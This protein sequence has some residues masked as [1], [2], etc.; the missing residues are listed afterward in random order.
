MEW[1]I[2]YEEDLNLGWLEKHTIFFNHSRFDRMVVQLNCYSNLSSEHKYFVRSGIKIKG[3][4][5]FTFPFNEDTLKAF[6]A[7]G[8]NTKKNFWCAVFVKDNLSEAMELM[9]E[10]KQYLE[11]FYHEKLSEDFQVTIL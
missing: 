11:D 9:F 7:H 5:K 1:Q 4:P 2:K 10:L 3:N 8:G 6:E